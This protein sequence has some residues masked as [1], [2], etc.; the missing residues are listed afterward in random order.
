[1]KR[2]TIV[3]AIV[4]DATRNA[5]F[6]RI[7][8]FLGKKSTFVAPVLSICLDCYL[9]FPCWFIGSS[10]LSLLRQL[11]P[12]LFVENRWEREC[13]SQF[14]ILKLNLFY[15]FIFHDIKVQILGR[16]LTKFVIAKA[17]RNIRQWPFNRNLIHVRVYLV[18]TLTASSRSDYEFL[19]VQTSLLDSQRERRT[20]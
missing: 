17:S 15:D 4:D 11:S 10:L 1:M 9:A 16:L 2:R 12:I 14:P 7:P 6:H 13:K 20:R 18:G 8:F 3:T 5:R 19:N